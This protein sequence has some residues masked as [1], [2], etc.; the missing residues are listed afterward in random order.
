MIYPNKVSE[1]QNLFLLY[2]QPQKFHRASN[3]CL[4]AIIWMSLK[5]SRLRDFVKHQKAKAK[6]LA[7]EQYE[8]ISAQE[9]RGILDRKS[10]V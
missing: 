5:Y 4:T 9:R 7:L 6:H 10:V 1:H 2:A 3:H 8:T